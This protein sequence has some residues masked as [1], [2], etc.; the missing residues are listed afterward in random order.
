MGHISFVRQNGIRR[1][2]LTPVELAI[3]LQDLFKKWMA[4]CDTVEAVTEK[5]TIDQ[6]LSTMPGDLRIWVG[7]WK[8]KTA[9]EAGRLA[10]D[11][12]QARR[13]ESGLLSKNDQEAK[14]RE[15]PAIVAGESRK[16][17]ACGQ[18]GHLVRNCPK[19]NTETTPREPV[20]AKKEKTERSLVRCYNCGK[21]GHIAMN[22]RD[23]ALLCD[24]E[25][26]G[27]VTKK[28]RVEGKEADDI[29]LD[30]GCSR[31]MVQRGLVPDKL[32]SYVLF[33]YREVPQES[34]GFSPFELVYG[35]EVRGP[36]DMLKETWESTQGSKEDV[37][38]Y[39]MLMRERLEKMASLVQTNMAKAQNQQK[40]WYDRTARKRVFQPGEQVLVLLPT[41]TSKLTAQWQG[42]YQVVKA[43]GRVNY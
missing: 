36:L 1:N 8:P 34:T 17:H 3:R 11:Y 26:G 41:S 32:L 14:R 7:E 24:E 28:G 9:G 27:A 25:M 5:M 42:P 23:N 43:M 20:T 16:C 10:D 18:G 40:R 37:L 19:R 4:G 12:M 2:G 6:L 31:T 33:A 13:R 35:R 39:V 29:L 30:T 22:C 21:R 15:K 38:S